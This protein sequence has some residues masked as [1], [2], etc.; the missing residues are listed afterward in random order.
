MKIE[1]YPL[2]SFNT[3][4]PLDKTFKKDYNGINTL[5][6]NK[7]VFDDTFASSALDYLYSNDNL[8]KTQSF[9][10]NNGFPSAEERQYNREAYGA[11]DERKLVLDL[12][13]SKSNSILNPQLPNDTDRAF[14][15]GLM[16]EEEEKLD[17]QNQVAN[18]NNSIKDWQNVFFGSP[19][20]SQLNGFANSALQ[21][22]NTSSTAQP[23]FL[24]V[25]PAETFDFTQENDSNNEQFMDMSDTNNTLAMVNFNHNNY[26]SG[27]TSEDQVQNPDAYEFGR[28]SDTFKIISDLQK[29]WL[30]TDDPQQRDALHNMANEARRLAREGTPLKYAQDE[31]MDLLHANA[32]EAQQYIDTLRKSPLYDWRMDF[33]YKATYL[34]AMVD[35]GPWDYK[36]NSE[37]WRVPVWY[38][39]YNG[40][41]LEY[42]NENRRNWMAW[43]YFDG[44]IMGADKLGNMNMAYVGAKLGLPR[45][46]YQN[47]ITNDKDD[48][49]WIQYGIDLAEQGR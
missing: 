20:E 16:G 25:K 19:L 5:Q 26:E 28:D 3:I 29:R 43:I 48:P 39:T 21:K 36:L 40:E 24:N 47:F 27:Y 1:N 45:I 9:L 17:Y 23:T 2:N 15:S 42:N 7:N 11:A 44:M 30:A 34:I 37:T 46:V 4:F 31:V 38:T 6:K 49:F 13:N 32:Q 10:E 22:I 18:A 14:L 41:N 8:G 35:K 12:L 33:D